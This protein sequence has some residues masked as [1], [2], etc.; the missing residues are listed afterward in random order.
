[1]PRAVLLKMRE[2]R[3][4]HLRNDLST[5]DPSGPLGDPVAVFPY[6]GKRSGVLACAAGASK[7]AWFVHACG[8]V[9]IDDPDPDF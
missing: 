2:A 9:T 4:A 1:V 5:F 3:S 8:S 7:L 6:R